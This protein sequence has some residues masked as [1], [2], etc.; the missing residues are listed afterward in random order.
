MRQIEDSVEKSEELMSRAVGEVD[1][2]KA[3][4]EALKQVIRKGTIRMNFIS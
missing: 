1:G 3:L 4:T 2:T